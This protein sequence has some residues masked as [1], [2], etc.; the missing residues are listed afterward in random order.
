MKNLFLLP[1]EKPSRLFKHNLEDNVLNISKHLLYRNY[2]QNIYITSEE[3]IK[4]V[5]YQ[6]YNP[7]GNFNNAK[8]SKAERLLESDGRRKKIILTTDTDLIE[9]G[10]QAIDDEFLEW[11]VKNPSF[12]EVDVKS[13]FEANPKYK[14]GTQ[15][16]EKVGYWSYKIIIPK[17]STKD[18]IM[19]ETSKEIKQKAK[20]YGN[21]LVMKQTAV[22]W[23]QKKYW[24]KLS[25]TEDLIIFQQAK[26]MEKQQ[27][28]YS[29]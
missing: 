13:I 23:L 21:S 4:E 2:G 7:L 27:Q 15:L 6:L 29:E 28:G 25:T 1:T 14:E 18:R 9:D 19:S 17:Q 22:E 12:E 3:E 16:T 20:D 8:V 11:F 10:V 26:E 5:E 24:K